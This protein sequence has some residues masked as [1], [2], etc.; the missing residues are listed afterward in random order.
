[1]KQFTSPGLMHETGC[2]GLVTGMTL[3]DGIGKE[4]GGRIRMGNL[5]LFHMN[6]WQKPPQYCKVISLQLKKKKR[7]E[8]KG[9]DVT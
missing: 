9:K 4:V 6:V 1:M 5:W 7:K 2:L 3:R 8:K